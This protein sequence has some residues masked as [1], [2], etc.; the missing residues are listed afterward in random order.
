M[1]EMVMLVIGFILFPVV[2]WALLAWTWW[3]G[4]LLGLDD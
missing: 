3:I 2:G 1:N 4:K